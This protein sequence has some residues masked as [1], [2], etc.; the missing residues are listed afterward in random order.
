L[1]FHFIH[2]CAF[3]FQWVHVYF[4]SLHFMYTEHMLLVFVCLC[5][6]I[7]VCAHVCFYFLYDLLQSLKQYSANIKEVAA[8][9]WQ[10]CF[11]VKVIKNI[12]H[13]L[14][15]V[16]YNHS[17]VCDKSHM[18]PELYILYVCVCVCVCVCVYTCTVYK[19]LQLVN[20][21]ITA[22]SHVLRLLC[23]G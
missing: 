21:L 22:L 10:D 5:V 3:T 13:F 17:G 15:S 23:S 6:H 2:Y 4:L 8:V 9:L 1:T 14:H 16:E 7:C 11:D 18:H 12:P 19:L 20:G